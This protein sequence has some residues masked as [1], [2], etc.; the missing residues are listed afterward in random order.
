MRGSSHQIFHFMSGSS[1][2][3]KHRQEGKRYGKEGIGDST[4]SIKDYR[5]YLSTLLASSWIRSQDLPRVNSGLK[6]DEVSRS[7]SMMEETGH[8]QESDLLVE[9]PQIE[10]YRRQKLHKHISGKSLPKCRV[11]NDLLIESRQKSSCQTH[12]RV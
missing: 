4:S 8:C 5:C 11:V 6:V 3:S 9:P 1:T 7:T 2:T 10:D 12:R